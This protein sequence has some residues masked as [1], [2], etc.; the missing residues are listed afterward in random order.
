MQIIC[1]WSYILERKFTETNCVKMIRLP[2]WY[3][4]KNIWYLFC[5]KW[6]LRFPPFW[7]VSWRCVNSRCGDANVDGS[8][9][10]PLWG[11]SDLQGGIGSRKSI[12]FNVLYTSLH[13]NIH[14]RYY[15]IF[16]IN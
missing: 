4:C 11:V 7:R 12:T 9:T 15:Y 8:R 14:K 1:T 13:V 2:R 6:R 10:E 3:I 16:L 5:V